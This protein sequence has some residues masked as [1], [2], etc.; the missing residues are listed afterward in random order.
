MAKTTRS[1]AGRAKRTTNKAT[2]SE[3]AVSNTANSASSNNSDELSAIERLEAEAEQLES[4]AAAAAE[5]AAQAKAAYIARQTSAQSRRQ[6][7]STSAPTSTPVEGSAEQDGDGNYLNMLSRM[8]DDMSSGDWDPAKFDDMTQG[9]SMVLGSGPAFAALGSMLA[10]STAQGS[11]LVNATQMQRQLDQVGLC[12]TSACVK[13]L[14]SIS[15]NQDA[16]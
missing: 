6:P 7:K 10:N 15:Q 16:G 3:E 8:F 1:T 9:I 12:T 14:L 2:P 13:Q 4:M 5:A 11:V